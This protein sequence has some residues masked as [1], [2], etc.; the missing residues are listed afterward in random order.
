[1]VL[2]YINIS[3]LCAQVW[4]TRYYVFFCHVQLWYHC[5][6]LS[7]LCAQISLTRLFFICYYGIIVYI[8]CPDIICKLTSHQDF[9]PRVS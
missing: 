1:M 3:H 6:L 9:V 4:F 5:V 8:T 7:L 2:W